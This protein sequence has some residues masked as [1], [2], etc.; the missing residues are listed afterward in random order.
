M[1]RH[2]PCEFFDSLDKVRKLH[3]VRGSIREATFPVQFSSVQHVQGAG[4]LMLCVFQFVVTR[5]AV[6][7]ET[8]LSRVFAKYR[9]AIGQIRF[10]FKNF[11]GGAGTEFPLK[12]RLRWLNVLTG[13]IR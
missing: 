7:D 4:A 3:E 12:S 9:H 6:H 10:V 13:D 11:R 2:I 5:K 1:S 8:V